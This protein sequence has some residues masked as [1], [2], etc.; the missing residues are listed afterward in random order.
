M[1]K[2]TLSI[3]SLLFVSL[4]SCNSGETTEEAVATVEGIST[5]FT[6]DL[7]SSAVMWKGEMLGL[8][9]HEGTVKLTEGTASIENGVVRSGKFTVDLATINPTDNGYDAENTKEKLIGHLSSDDFFNTTTFPTASFE[10][11]SADSVSVSGNLTV[12]GKTN[13][14]KVENV[15]ISEVDGTIKITGDLKF[16]R[17]KYDV[18]FSTGA[19]EKVLSNDI[20]LKLNLVS[21][22]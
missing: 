1:K 11:T 13:A 3:L 19:A 9:S 2:I 8:Y 15:T 18:K 16:D 6:A 17:T 22:K 20:T 12:R 5:D 21:K 10:V 7:D 14:E 4:V